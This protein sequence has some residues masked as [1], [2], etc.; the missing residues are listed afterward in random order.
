MTTSTQ[1]TNP[2][3]WIALRAKEPEF[4]RFLSAGS[5]EQASAIAVGRCSDNAG[6]FVSTKFHDFKT[7]FL[8]WMAMELDLP[9]NSAASL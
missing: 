2:Q 1:A 4:Q 3:A 9:A 6:T 5:A 7:E 8:T